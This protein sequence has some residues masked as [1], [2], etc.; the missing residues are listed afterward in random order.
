MYNVLVMTR[1]L[2]Q[3][4]ILANRDSFVII[5]SRFIHI[6]TIIMLMSR[7]KGD[8]SG[9]IHDLCHKS[10]RV[11]MSK[12]KR[13][14]T[15]IVPMHAS[16]RHIH[17]RLHYYCV[18]PCVA[19]PIVLRVRTHI[20]PY[21]AVYIDFLFL[22]V[23]LEHHRTYWCPYHFSGQYKKWAHL[24]AFRQRIICIVPLALIFR[25]YTKI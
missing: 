1:N 18:T 20:T 13:N 7:Q 4:V 25:F 5:L 6:M 19:W 22:F 21:N 2:R 17:L 3:D 8:E 11:T 14:D 12:I 10:W 15:Y 9:W 16:S 23:L 24:I